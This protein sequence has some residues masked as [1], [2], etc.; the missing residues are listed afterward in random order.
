MDILHNIYQ[1]FWLI[2]FQFIRFIIVIIFFLPS[3]GI[4]PGAWT[5]W[6][7]L[8]PPKLGA[9]LLC[10]SWAGTDLWL[11]PELI[12]LCIVYCDGVTTVGLLDM[13]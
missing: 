1:I 2:H 7:V 10:S 8:E 3:S 11:Y 4:S 5:D 13:S 9:A 12:T 6:A